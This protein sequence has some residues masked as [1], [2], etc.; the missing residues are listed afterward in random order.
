MIANQDNYLLL[1]Q[2][3]VFIE[4][5]RNGA[6]LDVGEAL[7]DPEISKKTALDRI[8][9]IED[10]FTIPRFHQHCEQT[11]VDFDHL[12][13]MIELMGATH[14][15]DSDMGQLILETNQPNCLYTT[16]CERPVL[17]NFMDDHKLN[18]Q[19]DIRFDI[20]EER[21]RHIGITV[22]KA[23]SWIKEWIGNDL[24]KT[25]PLSQV[26]MVINCIQIVDEMLQFG[27]DRFIGC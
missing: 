6:E 26:V 7:V 25:F 13:K 11:T 22:D 5:Q 16:I 14:D 4:A 8:Q 1:K 15:S 19:E 17:D 3:L 21:I 23:L 27:N 10:D 9:Q 12:V 24:D 20:D 18:L 2:T